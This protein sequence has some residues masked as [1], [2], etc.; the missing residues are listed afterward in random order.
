[1]TAVLKWITPDA[2]DMI[3][4]IARVSNPENRDNTAT[5]HALLV[6]LIKHAHWSPFQM[7]NLCIE[8]TDIS[9]AIA[10]QILRHQSFTGFQELSQ[11]Y[12]FVH[13][14][15]PPE[16]RCQ[17]AKNR[18]SSH[19]TFSEEKKQYY[20]DKTKHIFIQLDELY[21]EIIADGGSKET[22]RFL[23]PMCTKT[24]LILNGSIR[25]WMFYLKLRMGPETQLEHRVIAIACYEI[26]KEHLPTIAAAFF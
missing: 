5:A 7:A 12:A 1:M 8:L 13:T 18:Q 4:N 16:Q 21:D 24:T 14:P 15:E 9:R 17:D 11:R 19:D 3:V 6:Y 2:E 25:T 10:A 26:F 23:M 20:R 22:A